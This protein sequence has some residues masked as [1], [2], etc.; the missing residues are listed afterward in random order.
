MIVV[1]KKVSRHKSSYIMIN[2]RR[3]IALSDREFKSEAEVIRIRAIYPSSFEIH[4]N[5]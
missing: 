3:L 2:S 1:H 5:R 4:G